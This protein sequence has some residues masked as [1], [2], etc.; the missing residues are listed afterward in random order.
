[1]EIEPEYEGEYRGEL[2]DIF[3]YT[4][5]NFKLQDRAVYYYPIHPQ[6]SIIFE[7][8]LN[9]G[10][11]G[12]KYTKWTHVFSEDG[13]NKIKI[14]YWI[15]GRLVYQFENYSVII[16]TNHLYDYNGDY[17]VIPTHD[18]DYGPLSPTQLKSLNN[19]KQN[20]LDE[21]NIEGIGRLNEEQ[22]EAVNTVLSNLDKFRVRGVVGTN[23]R[24]YEDSFPPPEWWPE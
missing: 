2:A 12:L 14:E 5:P 1:M 17:L 7:S 10:L 23:W 6:R 19:L 8:R 11:H 16:S 24:L 20:L 9:G 18:I 21:E 4:A 3:V 15:H 22:L 13:I